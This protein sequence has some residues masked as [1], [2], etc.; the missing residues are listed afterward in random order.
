MLVVILVSRTMEV[1]M[2]DTG[3]GPRVTP[4]DHAMLVVWG[5]FAKKIGVVQALNQVPIRQKTRDHTPQT[6][7]VEFLVETL[8]GCAHLKELDE[9]HHPITH[10]PTVAEAWGVPGWAH[11]SGVSRTLAACSPAVVTAILQAL[12]QVTQP[13]LDRELAL[14]RA[15]KEHLWWDMDLTC[16]PVSNTS[17]TYPDA[18]FGWMSDE[19]GL[20]YQAAVVAVRS[21]TYGR[22]LLAAQRHPGD[23]VSVACLHELVRLAER[24][25]G[26]R[27]W[28]RPDLVEQRLQ[29]MQ[30]RLQK[31]EAEQQACQEQIADHSTKLDQVCQQQTS[32]EQTLQALVDAPR[33]RQKP[34][35][36]YSRQ[37]QT[38][39]RLAA[40]Q[41]RQ[42]NWQNQ[43][44][45]VQKSLELQRQKVTD[46]RQQIVR[47]QAHHDQLVTENQTNE[48][49]VQIV[50]RL[51]AGFASG[52]NLT[53][54]IEQG[55][56]LYT[57]SLN[58]AVTAN[59]RLRVTD[60]VSWQ[61]VGANAEMTA[62]ANQNVSQCAYPLD[63]GLERFQTGETIRH[64][65][66]LHYGPQPVIA[67]WPAWFRDYNGRQSIEAAN[68]ES[69]GVLGMRRPKVR[70]PSGLAIQ[71]QFALF[72]ANMIRWAGTWIAEAPHQAPPPFDAPQVSVKQMVQ[73][74]A[75]T[76]AQIIRQPGT[77]AVVVVFAQSSPFA[78]CRLVLGGWIFQP[79]LPL[80]GG[81]T[82]DYQS[83]RFSSA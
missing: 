65:T 5:E 61:E 48:A 1:T 30:Q 18:A 16:R 24:R 54:L 33:P 34:E 62:W 53:W 23:T 69:K 22:F 81:A 66:L 37:S 82:C 35:G 80:F 43:L 77:T 56:A 63:V 3:P 49:P 55:Y 32:L 31:E 36:I 29:A 52:T 38:R 19:V 42:V 6:K 40:C 45:R 28:R 15:Q 70:S 73:V 39:Q 4:T 8:A 59:L 76:S 79:A 20:G 50:L 9:G 2:S 17:K 46:L 72:A 10:D 26:L 60:E 83:A 71:E 13:F 58:Q 27:P 75:N 12:E 57:K 14:L 21:P 67:D 25:T 74:A 41:R 44:L 68:K 7:L 51:D 47:L 78:N 11:Y 64:S